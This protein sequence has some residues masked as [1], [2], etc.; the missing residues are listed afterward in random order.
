MKKKVN[1]LLCI[2]IT[3]ASTGCK[4]DKESRKGI[5]RN[6]NVTKVVEMKNADQLQLNWKELGDLVREKTE[7]QSELRQLLE[8]HEKSHVGYSGAEALK[9]IHSMIREP[10]HGVPA[11]R[12]ALRFFIKMD[13]AEV[14][15]ESL[16]HKHPDVVIIASDAITAQAR[17]GRKDPKA[18]QYLI[19]VLDNNNYLQVGSEE[20][21]LHAIMKRKL[22]EAIKETADLD[23]EV[24]TI[25][26]NDAEQIG[27]VLSMAKTWA[28]QKGVTLIAPSGR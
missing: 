25:V 26:V 9:S 20:A 19:S 6:S 24:A 16:L 8:R 17:R 13:A 3:W 10:S 11:A 12:D 22:V 7:F 5:E 1:L 2:V 21:T 4:D 28:R 15:R 23:I 14:V 18:I 27:Q